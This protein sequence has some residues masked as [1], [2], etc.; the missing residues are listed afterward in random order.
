MNRRA[1]LL[2]GGIGLTGLVTRGVLALDRSA[3]AEGYGQL[4]PTAAQNTGEVAL[5]L[6]EGFSYNILG[7]QG[8]RMTDGNLTPTKHD[9]MGA[10]LVN[11]KL[12]LVRNHEVPNTR[13][14]PLTSILQGESVY[15]TS[16]GGGTTTLTVDPVTRELTESRISLAGTHTN[17]AGGTT[18]WGSWLS[19]EETTL[20]P[21]L[22]KDDKGKVIGGFEKEHGYI[23]EVP[24]AGDAPVLPV[25][26]KAMGRFV[27]EA[28]AV[29][30]ATGIIYETE[31]RTSAGFYRFLPTKPGQLTEGGRL[32]MLVIEGK[33]QAD[34]RKKQTVGEALACTWIEIDDPD[35]AAASTNPL[36][37]Y[38]S[39]K[40]KGGATFARLEGCWWG[41]GYVYLNATTGGDKLLGQVWRY[42][43]KGA[44][45]GELIL[46][47]ES[48]SKSVLWN[49]DN[50]CVTPRGGLVLCEDTY[51]GDCYLRGLTKKGE[52]FNFARNIYPG[53]EESEFAGACFSPMT[54]NQT[55]FVNLQ[56]PGVTL[57]IWGPWE[58]GPF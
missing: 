26:L 9:G 44:D 27:H 55:L 38:E 58:R 15:D 12:R 42:Q 14:R 32:Q 56:L 41:N 40:A 6:P 23:F 36:A 39:G 11:G 21:T 54:D 28:I 16:A 46:L 22:G 5:E 53:F 35:P 20:G 48:K 18:P 2:G 1:L 52:I 29:D 49:P 7:R 25:P 19:C 3:L 47:F 17:C 10:F 33:P 37:V 57:A 43:P 50:L 24:A 30:P 51:G 13:A 4:R 31:D 34:L 45:K 8:T